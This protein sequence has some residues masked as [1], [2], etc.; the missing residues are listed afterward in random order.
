MSDYN[1]QGNQSNGNGVRNDDRKLFIGG[2]SAETTDQDL[3][4]HFVQYGEIESVTLKTDSQT[5]RSRG[6]AFLVFDS[7][8]SV[9]RVVAAGEHIINGK[10]VD[11]KKSQS[12]QGKIFVGG[13][14]AETSDEEVKEF[15]GQF[16]T[17]VAVER[18]F[19]KMKNQK[20]AFCFVSYDSEAVVRELLKTPKQMLGG[21]E[22][23]VKA[24]VSRQ[25]M[26]G[27]G[28]QMGGRG[29]RGGGFGGARRS[30]GGD[31]GFGGGFNQSDVGGGYGGNNFGFG[32]YDNSGNGGFQG[33]KQRGGGGNRQYQP[34]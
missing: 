2:I 22:V 28:M 14:S 17:V 4:N 1:Q 12:K 20:K 26:G 7:A 19:D 11:A 34:Y 25:D 24:A 30:W 31:Q 29:G 9:G 8:D 33:G 21:R 6:F 5:G 3:R 13:L 23:D 15:F 27:S 18:P 10:Q 16:G 32:N